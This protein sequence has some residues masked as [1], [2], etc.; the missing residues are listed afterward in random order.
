[1]GNALLLYN[2]FRFGNIKLKKYSYTDHR[3]GSPMN[4]I[5]LM[6]KGSAKLISKGKTVLVKTGDLF[7]IPYKLPYQS[8]W[9]G[10]PD[11]EFVSIGFLNIEATEKVSFDL[12]VINCSKAT[13]D[14]VLKIPSHWD[15]VSCESLSIFYAVLNDILLLSNKKPLNR[16]S[17]IVNKAKSFIKANTDCSV[18]EIAEHLFISEPYLYSVFKQEAGCT[19]NDYKLQIK[20]RN[21]VNSLLSTDKTVEQISTE[22]GFSSAA[23][24][25]KALKKIIN[26]TPKEI[27]KNK[28]F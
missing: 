14:L 18:K 15:Y 22:I 7:T 6:K 21:G 16:K 2:N 17:E 28:N 26:A 23:H 20:C 9:Y 8:Y 24:F 4:Y 1:M 5:G 3:S 10:T 19:P 13:K 11:I 25:R 27:R 12:Q